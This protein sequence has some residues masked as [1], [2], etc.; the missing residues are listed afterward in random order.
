V[1]KRQ[2]A[3]Y[4]AL[5]EAGLASPDMRAPLP[6]PAS[7]LDAGLDETVR[8]VYRELGGQSDDPRIAPGGWDI[9]CDNMTIELDEERHFN[10]YR[11]ATLREPV[12]DDLSVFDVARYRRYC[13]AYEPECLRTAHHG[14]YWS[15]PSAEREFGQAGPEGELSGPGAPRWRQ[16]A[17][18]DFIKDLTPFTGGAGVV[19]V[20]IWDAIT[21]DETTLQV[22][23][24]LD[25]LAKSPHDLAESWSSSLV[26]LIEQRHSA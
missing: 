25:R 1:G 14:G 10:R 24:V 20:S 23:D 21:V 7:I 3:L 5:V 18:Y 13:D 4:T 16:R 12:Y 17:F 26:A 8:R 6:T 2:N 19:R 9:V 11:L 15:N 22:R